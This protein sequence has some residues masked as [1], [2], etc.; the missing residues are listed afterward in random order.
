MPHLRYGIT[1]RTSLHGCHAIGVAYE[2]HRTG[3]ER[4]DHERGPRTFVRRWRCF[5]FEWHFATTH[6]PT[7]LFQYLRAIDLG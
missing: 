2:A 3:V 4:I 5:E 1:Q 7:P 6:F